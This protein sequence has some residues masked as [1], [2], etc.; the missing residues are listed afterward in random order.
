ANR[1]ITRTLSSGR[2]GQAH[3][4]VGPSILHAPKEDLLTHSCKG[5]AMRNSKYV[6]DGY[7]RRGFIAE[8]PG[9]HAAVRFTFRPARMQER[10]TLSEAT[11]GTSSEAR[12]RIV[13]S[14]VAERIVT[15]DL[16]DDDGREIA[17]RTESMS[18]LPPELFDALQAV[19]LGWTAGD[20]D[21][22]WPGE[23]RQR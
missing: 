14:F 9:V 2:F 10:S 21:P 8:A 6:Q 12:D 15:W 20:L 3:D 4:R 23:Y 5:A 1:A 16:A 22:C 11:M 17:V 18:H 7:T 13:A 19:V